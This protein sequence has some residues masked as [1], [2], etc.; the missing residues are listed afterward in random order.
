MSRHVRLGI[1]GTSWWADYLYLPSLVG[2]PRAEVAALCGRNQANAEEI[3]KK[4]GVGQIFTD[5]HV[6]L[7]AVCLSSAHPACASA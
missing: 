4:Y 3:A 2:H 1:V 6:F 5:Y 7:F